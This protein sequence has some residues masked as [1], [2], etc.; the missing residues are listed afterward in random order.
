VLFVAFT[1]VA[2][3]ELGAKLSD[4]LAYRLGVFVRLEIHVILQFNPGRALPG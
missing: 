3:V 4:R 1:P 2:V